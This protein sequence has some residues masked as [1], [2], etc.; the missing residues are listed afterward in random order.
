VTGHDIA[1]L[2]VAAALIGFVL[3]VVAAGIDW[4]VVR[5]RLR[6]RRRRLAAARAPRGPVTA[7]DLV[8]HPQLEQLAEPCPEFCGDLTR[9]G[10]PAKCTCIGWCGKRWC[11]RR[12]AAR[13]ATR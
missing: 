1:R 6:A 10:N 12:P 5:A 9:V 4:H 7:A 3:W 8:I 2:I 11:L 13:G